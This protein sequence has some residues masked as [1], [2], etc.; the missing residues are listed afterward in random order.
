MAGLIL[1]YGGSESLQSPKGAVQP[2]RQ[3][4]AEGSRR[5]YR[6]LRDRVRAQALSLA[7]A[8]ARRVLSARGVRPR[9]AGHRRSDRRSWR[10]ISAPVCSTQ[11][12]IARVR[13]RFSVSADEQGAADRALRRRRDPLPDKTPEE[14]IALLET[15]QLPRLPDQ[16]LRLQRARPPIAS[17]AARSTSSALAS[18]MIP[19]GERA[20][21]RA[22]GLRR[23]RPAGG[24]EVAERDEPYIYHFPDGNASIARLLVRALIPGVAPRHDDGRHR[25]GAVRL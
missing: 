8:V 24:S 13:R 5:R 1:G 12:R 16:D 4:P 21:D 23:A 10:T 22:A 7:R 19:A 25:A 6:A 3:G 14:K 17:T 11:S 18:D 15:H 20:R 9:H 2:G